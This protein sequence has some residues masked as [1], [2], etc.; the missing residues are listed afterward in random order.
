[1]GFL[2]RLRTFFAS[3]TPTTPELTPEPSIGDDELL[4]R[5]VIDRKH[6]D[7]TQTV[8]KPEAFLPHGDPPATSVFRAGG[9]SDFE[10]WTSASALP[11][12]EG[13]S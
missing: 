2:R 10:L 12:S 1:M 5:F 8:V 7:K 3:F 9:L 6:I 4:A 13:E 11:R